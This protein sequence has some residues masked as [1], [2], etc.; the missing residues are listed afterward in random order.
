MLISQGGSDKKWELYY[1]KIH[2]YDA[3][4]GQSTICDLSTDIVCLAI[5]TTNHNVRKKGIEDKLNGNHFN[6]R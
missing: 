6:K 5:L 3:N 2:E 4:I 1:E